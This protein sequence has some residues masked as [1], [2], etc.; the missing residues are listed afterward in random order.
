MKPINLTKKALGNGALLRLSDDGKFIANGHW[1]CRRSMI[2]QGPALTSVEAA[3]ALYPA[4]DVKSVPGQDVERVVP[5]YG[6]PVVFKRTRWM[7][8]M[9]AGEDSVLF[10]ADDGSQTW[11]NRRYVDLFKLEEITGESC[12]GEVS[13]SPAIVGTGKSDWQIAVMPMRLD[14]MKE[15]GHRAVL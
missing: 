10:I 13:I 11:I 8:G 15:P 9:A 5:T 2:K 7:Q 3:Q 6:S 4:A 14:F 1:L 12:P